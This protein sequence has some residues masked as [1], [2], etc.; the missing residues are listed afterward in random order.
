MVNPVGLSVGGKNSA[1]K[2]H[3]DREARARRR[4]AFLHT[5]DR[6]CAH[7]QTLVPALWFGMNPNPKDPNTAPKDIQVPRDS[8]ID[9][10]GGPPMPAADGATM[11]DEDYAE[12]DQPLLPDSPAAKRLQAR[13]PR[14][15]DQLRVGTAGDAGRPT[16]EG[17]HDKPV[18]PRGRL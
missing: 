9:T 11:R 16:K 12:Q 5:A 2:N 6:K 3:A 4:S 18:P 10:G 13:P 1:H 8:R 7:R 17:I 14:G 15:R